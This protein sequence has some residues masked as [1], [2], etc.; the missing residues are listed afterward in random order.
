MKKENK[1]K[2][3]RSYLAVTAI[4][5]VFVGCILYKLIDT[6]V[7]TADKWNEVAL[8]K[9]SRFDTIAPNRGN[10]LAGDGSI[11]ATNLRQYT[12]RIDYQASRFD[13]TLFADTIDC[14]ADSMALA[15][16]QRSKKEWREYLMKPLVKYP[17]K[18]KR[19]KGYRLVD[20]VSHADYQRLRTFPFFSQKNRNRSGL[21]RESKMR[22]INP[23][24]S[25]ALRSIGRVSATS[26]NKEIHGRSGLEMALDSLLYGRVGYA[27]KVP[28]THGIVNWTDRAPV[29]GYNIRTTIDIK[30]Q[31][32]VENELNAMLEE[33]KADWGVAVL[34]EVAT[35]DI[36][37]ISN[38]EIDPRG[39]G[40]TEGMN[41]AVLGFEPG[42][43]IKPISMLIA[44]E[45]G[46]VSPHQVISTPSPFPYAGGRA[47]RDSH[48]VES[49]PVMEVV[50]RSSNVGM[51][52][53]IASKF[54]HQPGKF[55]SALRR[56]GFLDPLN[57][58]I[59]GERTPRIDSLGT[60]AGAR[61]ALSRQ[62]YGYATEIPPLHTLAM[63]N[64]I[65]NGGRFVRP[66]LVQHIFGS[67]LDSVVPVT[68]VRDRVCT[69]ANARVLRDM[70]RRVV[71]GKHGTARVLRN[72]NVAIAGKTGTAFVIED[73]R[74]TNKK[75]LAFCGFFPAE[76]P[77]YSCI[78]L[79]SNPRNGAGAA[80]TSGMVLKNVC[81]RL[82][83][84]GML[85]NS[86]MFDPSHPSKSVPTL[87]ATRT[88]DDARSLDE[89]LGVPGPRKVAAKKSST[90]GVPS[91]T[92][93]GIRDAIALL[94]KAGYNV[95]PT[96][97]GCVVSQKPAAGTSLRPGAT[98]KI[99]LSN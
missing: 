61:I 33:S 41:R 85:D 93:Y 20:N 5:L 13:S 62:C 80:R 3:L 51:T 86:L 58:G 65:A 55:Y 91:V 21:T 60:G 81:M 42:S 17:D 15:F 67:G 32:I 7:I 30:I 12:V 39:S 23:Y 98:V 38:L 82:F 66:R 36:K 53:I 70:M 74:Y 89:A 97:T 94:E 24:G 71:E 56:I 88:A 26:T 73:G 54:E 19:P 10:I 90:K 28:L 4:I 31:D 8:K 78:V 27:K 37:A 87:Y 46:A 76:K 69:E 79:I 44:L 2:I 9:L 11:L 14:L 63:Y 18:K 16:P 43:V 49:M 25:M 83:S 72:D 84:R 45:Q 68:Y 29:N 34:M 47:I 95:E 57:V 6:T 40:Y 96:G 59:G 35:G 48:P 77:K 99:Y 64:A 92:G 50:E 52:R 22:R 1:N 75:R